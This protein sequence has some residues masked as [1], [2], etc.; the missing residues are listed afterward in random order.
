MSALPATTTQTVDVVTLTVNIE[1]N[2]IPQTV[3]VLGAE[4]VT[5]VNRIPFARLRIGDGDAA[6]GDFAGSSGQ[7]FV[8][9][10]QV[11]ILAGYQGQTQSIFSGLVVSQRLVVRG[12]KSWLEIDCRDPAFKMTLTRHNRYFESVTDSDVAESLL[13]EYDDLT[14]DITATDVTHT[15]LLQYQATD[16]DFLVSRLE[17]T[18]QL[19]WAEGGTVHSIKPSL[20]DDAT[21]DISYGMTL[22]EL[23]A[24]LDARTQ[25]GGVT[26]VAWDPS[27]QDVIQ[28]SASDP[29]WAGNGNLSADDLSGATGRSEDQVWH[30]GSL[31]SDALQV[32]ADG[33]LLRARM[34]ESI[35]RARFQGIA[36]LKPGVVLQLS[37]LSD[38][39]NG[40]VCVTGVRQE[41]AGGN[42]VTDA[43]FGLTRETHAERMPISH[44]P[45]AGIAAAVHGLQVGVVTDLANDPDGEY[46]IRVKV[47]L[48]GMDEQGV[49]ARVATLDAGNQ[50]GMFFRPEV[51]DEVV[52]GFFHADP[53]HPVVLGMLNSSAKPPAFDA[54]D[55]NDNK[56]YVSRSKL[57]LRFDDKNKVMVLETPGGNRLTLSDQDGG[58]TLEDQ[59]GNS[60]KLDSNGITLTSSKGAVSLQ[61]KTDFKVGAMNAQIKADSSLTA[62]GTASAELST[63]GSL[64]VK[65][66]TVMIN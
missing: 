29:Q 49:W 63:S 30:G 59:N 9:G 14:A 17:T 64:T 41:F 44:I 48:A 47:P 57:A 46:R 66:T 56:G 39:F 25:T 32:W 16:W 37:R 7:L 12:G 22:L 55:D 27:G 60:L 24:E 4:V 13:G 15:Q 65:G 58:V 38:R 54:T 42:W 6:R 51:K 10:N 3:P 21:A 23:D 1:G 26:A 35:G 2:E 11:D 43:Q 8:P 53:S 52:L 18:G 50:R 5:Q 20:D 33:A 45:A 40:K 28:S 19:C 34:A 31:A 61:A 62:K 36:T